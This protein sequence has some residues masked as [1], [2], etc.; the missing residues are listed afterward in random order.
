M[1]KRMKKLII[2]GLAMMF[3]LTG[4]MGKTTDTVVDAPEATIEVEEVVV[5]TEEP[6]EEVPLQ[7]QTTKREKIY[8]SEETGKNYM[9]LQYCDVTVE[10]SGREDLKRTVENWSMEAG[11]GMRTR[12]D[13]YKE[14]AEEELKNNEDFYGYSFYQNVTIARADE[15]II[16]FLVDTSQYTDGEDDQILSEG[17]NFDVK[18][19][20]VLT[21]EDVIVDYENFTVEATDQMIRKLGEVYGDRLFENYEES[22]KNMWAQEA[23]PQWYADAAGLVIMLPESFSEVMESNCPKMH[24]NYDGFEY[25]IREEYAPTA[26]DG[27]AKLDK[28]EETLVMLPGK[29]EPVALALRYEWQGDFPKTTLCLGGQ[30]QNIGDFATVESAYFIRSGKEVY[31]MVAVDMASDDFVT[32]IYRLTEGVIQEV[33]QIGANIDQGNISA[34]AVTMESWV[35]LLGTYNGVKHYRF[36]KDHGFTSEDK[37]FLLERNNYELTTMVDLPITMEGKEATLPAGSKI[38]LT[39]TDGESYVKFTIPGTGQN[40]TL[41]VSRGEEEFYELYINGISEY[42]CFEQLPYA[43]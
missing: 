2:L 43:G 6:V 22:I 21:L 40:G 38:V 3:A 8:F 1:K 5:M 36:D 24:L 25:Y 42:E 39:A 33:D 37:E 41:Q 13:A 12:V 14:A 32:T 10:G 23:E 34:D 26:T 29:E 31:C 4:C 18:T 15:N 20:R 30:Q 9:Y 17:K 11:A 35:Y 28:N 16:S 7:V 27:V 19:G